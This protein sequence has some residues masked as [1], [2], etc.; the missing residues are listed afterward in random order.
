MVTGCPAVARSVLPLS[1]PSKPGAYILITNYKKKTI[2]I[3]ARLCIRHILYVLFGIRSHLGYDTGCCRTA[4][5]RDSGTA[6]PPRPTCRGGASRTSSGR[7]CRVASSTHDTLGGSLLTQGALPSAP[8]PSFRTS[9]TPAFHLGERGAE[10]GR[11]R[12]RGGWRERGWRGMER[13]KE[14]EGDGGRERERAHQR[15]EGHASQSQH[16]F[17]R[18]LFQNCFAGPSV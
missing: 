13:E 7:R 1:L 4:E 18:I 15:Y 17:L 6:E 14:G 2:L 8:T 10:R 5:Q 11:G 16:F 12:E 3:H 9:S